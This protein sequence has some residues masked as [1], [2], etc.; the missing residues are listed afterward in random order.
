MTSFSLGRLDWFYKDFMAGKYLDLCDIAKLPLISERISEYI[1]L[2]LL[3][4][5][6]QALYLS[7]LRKLSNEVRDW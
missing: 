2:A 6:H 3:I 5:I 7:L 1:F 4:Q